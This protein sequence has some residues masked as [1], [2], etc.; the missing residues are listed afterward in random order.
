MKIKSLNSDLF[1]NINY[2]E[3]IGTT[4]QV[5]FDDMDYMDI[6]GA[7]LN[8]SH[9]ELGENDIDYYAVYDTPEFQKWL[10]GYYR[11]L[12]DK[13]LDLYRQKIRGGILKVWRGMSVNSEHEISWDRLGW[14]W[15]YKRK[16]AE[17]FLADRVGED[18]WLFFAEVNVNDV[19]WI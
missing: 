13:H 5:L 11:D 2:D 12:I 8:M 7:Y 19:D 1:N 17:R 15:S 3:I 16:S 9:H 18:Q 6:V 4:K 14:F 10:D